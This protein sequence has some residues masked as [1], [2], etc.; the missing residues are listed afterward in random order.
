MAAAHLPLAFGDASVV[1]GVTVAAIGE[2]VQEWRKRRRK[3]RRDVDS[4]SC[5]YSVEAV[6]Q[7]GGHR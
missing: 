1:G 6:E 3:G 7:I 4:A 2:A 5:S